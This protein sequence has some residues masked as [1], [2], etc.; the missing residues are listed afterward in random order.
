M[1]NY[2][3]SNNTSNNIK[4]TPKKILLFVIIGFV[5]LLILLYVFISLYYNTHFYM[6]TIIN[7]VN[8]SNMTLEEVEAVI[9][10]Q[11]KTY[12]LTLEG[13]NKL[14]DRIYGED[15]DLHTVFDKSL[16]NLL[17]AQNNF[18]WP[19]VLFKVHK[20]EI[21]I[22]LEYDES[23]LKNLVS[24]LPYFKEENVVEPV[25]AYISEYSNDSGYEI[26][27]ENPGTKVSFDVLLD[28]VETAIITSEPAIFLEKINCYVNPEITFQSTNL[29]Q[30]MKELNQ[31]AGTKIT[32]E[33]DEDIEILDGS[34]I[35]EWLSVDED[36]HVALDENGVQA[37]VDYIGR[38]YNSFGK[39]RTL[40]L[41][42]MLR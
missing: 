24:K 20:M 42:T 25:N 37:Y 17:S 18:A 13:R 10:A 16:V 2:S 36:Y 6:N 27:P 22:M 40:R 15:F 3:L 4:K 11:V 26:I 38:T 41:L 7:G 28:A 29:I 23:L 21:E 33:F 19:F 34:Q 1:E 9:Q 31:I 32:Y 14:T 35:S 8:T 5:S 12:S 30:A 39:T